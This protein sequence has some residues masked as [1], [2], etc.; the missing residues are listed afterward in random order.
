MNLPFLNELVESRMF[1]D[2]SSIEHKSAKSI[3][4]IVLLMTFAI[5]I[6]HHEDESLARKYVEKT[7]QY[8]DFDAMRTSQTDYYNLISVL[9]N[10]EKYHEKI[11]VDKSISIPVLQLKRYLKDIKYGNEHHSQ[12]RAF[13]IALEDFL[14]VGKYKSIRR[15]IG[16]WQQASTSEKHSVFTTLKQAFNEKA[17]QSDLYIAFKADVKM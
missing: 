4:E 12:D 9:A 13:L 6:L 11:E 14:K 15:I 10:Q 17:L 2:G 3:A 1:N 7:L 5:E 8:N 16:D